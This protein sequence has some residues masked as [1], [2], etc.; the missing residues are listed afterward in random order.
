M[1]NPSSFLEFSIKVAKE[2]G[3]IQM[4]YFGNIS[5]IEKKSTNIDL[6][7][8]ADKESETFIINQ[9]QKEYP[10][11]SILSEERGELATNSDYLWIIDPLDGTTNFSHNL[12]IFAVSIALVH[13]NNKTLCGVVYN[14]AANKCF[15]AEDNKGAFLDGKSINPT[16]SK[17]LSDSLIVTGFPYLHDKKYDVSFDIFKEF[18]DCTRGLR[19]LGA[20]ALDL[21]F[22]AMGRFDG[23]YEYSLEPWDMC[24]GA[25]IAKEAGASVT[26]WNNGKLP[27]DGSRILATNGLIHQEMINILTKDK[28]RLFY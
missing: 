4:K 12:P 7:T 1:D 13:K 16:S 27:N 14:P 26:D 28:Y 3:A 24:A 10:D 18:Y 25:L 9:I 11:H 8:N 15:Y 22:V 21:C 17:T 2:A 6:L 5:S 20:A 19:R 23:Y